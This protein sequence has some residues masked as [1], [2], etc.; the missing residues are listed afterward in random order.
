[1]MDKFDVFQTIIGAMVFIGLV[2]TYIGIAAVEA[3]K[4][5]LGYI[6][7]IAGIM[8]ALAAMPADWLCRYLY[9]RSKRGDIDDK[10]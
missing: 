10:D 6:V 4:G 9:H 8:T 7:M 1:M 3:D 2:L 5:A